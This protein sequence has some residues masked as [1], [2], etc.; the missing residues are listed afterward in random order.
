MASRAEPVVLRAGPSMDQLREAF[1]EGL[2]VRRPLEA[3]GVSREVLAVRRPLE[4]L[5]ASREVLAVRQPLEALEAY[6]GV[7]EVLRAW[8]ASAA[9]L[10]APVVHQPSEA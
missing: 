4:A 7:L 10:E 9:C 8:A 3:L 2:E 6:L 1:R 5:G